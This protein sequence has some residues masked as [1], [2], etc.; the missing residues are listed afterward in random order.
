MISTSVAW[1]K[2]QSL[3]ATRSQKLLGSL[4]LH[5]FTSISW[6]HKSADCSTRR[7][8]A[9]RLL[10]S[11]SRVNRSDQWRWCLMSKLSIT[12]SH[13]WLTSNLRLG[14]SFVTAWLDLL[15]SRGLVCVFHLNYDLWSHSHVGFKYKLFLTT[16]FWITNVVKQFEPAI[17]FPLS[18]R[19]WVC[20]QNITSSWT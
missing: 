19:N 8:T 10:S 14:M 12:F 5:Q 20:E 6:W 18:T 13:G 2:H 16:S 9:V 4:L 1:L 3:L 15:L 11:P 17:Y 7:R